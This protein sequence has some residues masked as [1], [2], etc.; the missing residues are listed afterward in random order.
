MKLQVLEQD[1]LPDKEFRVSLDKGEY[2]NRFFLNF[3]PVITDID[4]N[5]YTNDLFSIYS[6]K[7][8]LRAEIKTLKADKGR[9]IIYN[10]TGQALFIKEVFETGYLEFN[11]GVK[12]GIYIIKYT[13]GESSSSKKIF[14]QNQ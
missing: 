2:L 11:P 4:N 6:Y 13:T 7:G 14:I 9:L 1:L 3:S 10:L 8:T 12:E 5:T